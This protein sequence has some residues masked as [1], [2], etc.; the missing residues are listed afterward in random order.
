MGP[1]KLPENPPQPP[2]VSKS[3]TDSDQEPSL[4]E[5]SDDTKN[6][7]NCSS[8]SSHSSALPSWL[9]KKPPKLTWSASSKTPTCAP[10]TP[11]ESPL[12]QKISNWLDESEENELKKLTIS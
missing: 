4:S 9:F 1:P 7:L 5:R 8:E 3:H 11:R 10:S 12:C 2:V 6:P